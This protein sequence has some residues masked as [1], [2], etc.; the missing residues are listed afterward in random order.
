[1]KRYLT[2]LL[3]SSV[4]S[5]YASTT[6][7]KVIYGEDNR[8]DAYASTNSIHK[9][10]ALSTAAMIANAQLISWSGKFQIQEYKTLEES[11]N[12]CASEKFSQQPTV[13]IC[14]GFLIAPDL[15][16]TAGHCMQPSMFNT[17][18]C[19]T[20]S[21][22]FDYKMVDEKNINFSSIESQNVYRCN[23]V[24]AAKLD[25]NSMLDYAV[26]KL[27]RPVVGRQPLKLRRAGSVTKGQNLAV[28]GHPTGLPTKIA[29]GN[30]IKSEHMNYF[31]TNLDTFHG[32]SGSVVIDSATGTVEGI[33]V[34]GKADYVPSIASNPESCQIVN[35][36]DNLGLR[37]SAAGQDLDGEHVTRI[38]T[39]LNLVP[40]SVRRAIK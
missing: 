36:C 30:V 12:V 17:N 13:A 21:W 3:L 28:I 40:Q 31:V 25:N 24:V 22:V 34:R 4:V 35:K 23:K 10:V 39:I 8:V 11:E 15:L 26:I 20:F 2:C 32:N 6:N 9:Q 38:S 16:V 29:T 18:P 37:C 27:D 14:S 19:G 1:M 5:A 33:L 7:T